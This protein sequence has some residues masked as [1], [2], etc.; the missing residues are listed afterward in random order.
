MERNHLSG[1]EDVYKRQVTYRPYT[2]IG[3]DKTAL[4]F[5][6][7]QTYQ[8][9]VT[10]TPSNATEELQLEWS[11]SDENVAVVSQEG[12]VTAVSAGNAV[13]TVVKAGSQ[14]SASCQVTVGNAMELSLIHI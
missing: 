6:A 7:E 14:I 9:Q 2:A 13:I 1:L 4:F 3:L 10:G 8:F 5:Q 11:S 12:L